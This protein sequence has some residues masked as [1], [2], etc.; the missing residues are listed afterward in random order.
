MVRIKGVLFENKGRES[1]SAVKVLGEAT[2]KNIQMC[3]P[4]MTLLLVLTCEVR[5]PRTLQSGVFGG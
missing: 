3:L 4:Y 1:R 2:H 5:R